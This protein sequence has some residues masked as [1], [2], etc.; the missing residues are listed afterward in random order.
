MR[1][2]KARVSVVMPTWA[3]SSSDLFT[4]SALS[5]LKSEIVGELVI[6]ED[7]P[8]TDPMKQAIQR[9][10]LADNRARSIRFSK[11]FG[12]GHARNQG[13]NS[14]K[15][16]FIAVNDDDDVSLPLRFEKQVELL[17]RTGADIC[18][19]NILEGISLNE[20]TLRHSIPIDSLLKVAPWIMPIHHTSM[21]VRRAIIDAIEYD[22]KLR[23]GEDYALIL[24]CLQARVRFCYCS[25]P[26]VFY[27]FGF[28]Q[29]SKRKGLK[30]LKSDIASFFRGIGLV[31]F[32]LIPVL[33][34]FKILVALSRFL[35][36]AT[37]DFVRNK[38][39]EFKS[40]SFNDIDSEKRS[41]IDRGVLRKHRKPVD[42]SKRGDH[43]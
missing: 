15:F 19:A 17:E 23:V 35:P 39:Y 25:E 9:V 10:A 29:I 40:T 2:S 38:I 34:L 27:R 5:A 12:P 18:Y 30:Y 3:G 26:L 21:M 13:F 31:P 20:S 14:A 11:A 42:T 24:D 8:L 6:V 1:D 36:N 7:G 41:V 28:S 43:S 4:E 32:Y 37:F 16:D 22:E 33:F